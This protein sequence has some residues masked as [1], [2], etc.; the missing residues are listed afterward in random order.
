[1]PFPTHTTSCAMGLLVP[2][3]VPAESN[4]EGGQ[5]DSL[6]PLSVSFASVSLAPEMWSIMNDVLPHPLG[7]AD[8]D[9]AQ[10]NELFISL[11]MGLPMCLL[12][13]WVMRG[14]PE[15]SSQDSDLKEA[16]GWPQRWIW[17]VNYQIGYGC[18]KAGTR[19]K[20][21]RWA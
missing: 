6:T 10:C 20:R 11:K 21:W 15:E 2:I 19:C 4:G 5:G 12:Q 18:D 16:A 9:L 13:W 1:M 3:L 7:L 14:T 8:P 17:S